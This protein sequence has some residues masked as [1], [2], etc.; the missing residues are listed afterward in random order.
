[1][2]SHVSRCHHAPKISGP[3]WR[4]CLRAA[5]SDSP[6][7]PGVPLASPSSPVTTLEVLPS[8]TPRLPSPPLLAAGS[9]LTCEGLPSAS[10]GRPPVLACGAWLLWPSLWKQCSCRRPSPAH[11]A[12]MAQC[13]FQSVQGPGPPA[14]GPSEPAACTQ[15]HRVSSPSPQLA[16]GSAWLPHAG[17]APAFLAGLLVCST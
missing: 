8:P 11:C 1:M 3:T 12:G 13:A 17:P 16:S 9:G 15:V 4:P 2:Q 14:P 6:W 10:V 5:W 7:G